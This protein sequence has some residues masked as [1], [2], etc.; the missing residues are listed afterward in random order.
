MRRRRLANEAGLYIFVQEGTK[1][2][3][4]SFGQ[5]AHPA[6]RRLSAFFEINLEVVRSM[7]RQDVG[8]GLAEDVLE[9]VELLWDEI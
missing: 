5:G 4:L 2:L 1:C 3:E 6:Y 9:V 7:W 8:A